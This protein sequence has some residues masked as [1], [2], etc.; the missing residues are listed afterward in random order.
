MKNK[1][2]LFDEIPIESDSDLDFPEYDFKPPLFIGRVIPP[3]NTIRKS[4]I[5][6]EADGLANALM[7]AKAGAYDEERK[8]RE[9]ALEEH[10]GIKPSVSD[11]ELIKEL[12]AP[13]KIKSKKELV[14]Q[15]PD[16]DEDEEDEEEEIQITPK[17]P[18][19]IDEKMKLLD[20]L[21][22][23]RKS[24]AEKND[25]S[26]SKSKN[27]NSNSINL[28]F[29]DT[30]KNDNSNSKRFSRLV[31]N[32]IDGDKKK[33]E[34][35]KVWVFE[36]DEIPDN[37]PKLER[38]MIMWQ[39]L[40]HENFSDTLCFDF[41]TITPDNFMKKLEESKNDNSN[42]IFNSVLFVEE[43]FKGYT[44]VVIKVCDHNLI[45]KNNFRDIYK[46]IGEEIKKEISEDYDPTCG[47]PNHGFFRGNRKVYSNENCVGFGLKKF[48]KINK[49][50]LLIGDEKN[51]VK[52][53]V[54]DSVEAVFDRELESSMTILIQENDNSNS[55]NSGLKNDNSNSKKS[56]SK[57]KDK[58]EFVK[59]NR[60]DFLIKT[61]SEAN[62]NGDIDKLEEII[63]PYINHKNN[64]DKKYTKEVMDVKIA[65]AR[66][67]FNPKF[68]K[69][70][71]FKE[72]PKKSYK[73][74]RELR[75]NGKTHITAWAFTDST[76]S[77]TTQNRWRAKYNKEFNIKAKHGI[78]GRT[79]K[80]K[81]KRGKKQDLENE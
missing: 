41:D 7:L 69:K 8:S 25:N 49:I 52:N 63:Y 53:A 9:K 45:S 72:T 46:L 62:L 29:L 58:G 11:E 2:A 24:E 43:S 22:K 66:K 44:H 79:W 5:Y 12:K 61:I 6:Y 56:K 37:K 26:N 21:Q 30:E 17:A 55:A 15:K 14:S 64:D 74:Y 50:S 54:F 48:L 33:K 32:L 19:T 1:N 68:R 20:E 81:E 23:K 70:N 65:W 10:L 31:R 27:D 80:L 34:D 16:E 36:L 42:S 47:E 57:S 51:S 13:H 78:K 3:K 28:D 67:T 38:D 39:K 60:N 75:I 18:M 71:V 76:I 59:G 77:V 73:A 35:W 4:N 40:D